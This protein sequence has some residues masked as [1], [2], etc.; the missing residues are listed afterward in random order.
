MKK[1]IWLGLFLPALL[2]LAPLPLLKKPVAAAT[3]AGVYYSELN[4]LEAPTAQTAATDVFTVKDHKTGEISQMTATDYI[5]GV[6]CGEMPI[7]FG[8]E[9]IKAQAVAAYTFACRRRQTNAAKNYDITTDYTVDQCYLSEAQ[10]REKWGDSAEENIAKIRTLVSEVSGYMVTYE[11]TAAL[12][13]YHATSAGKTQ[14]VSDVW[15]GELPYLCSVD[16]PGDTLSEGYVS[17]V[18][19]GRDEMAQKLGKICTVSAD[20]SLW[21]S[22][23][24]KNAAG[25]VSEITVCGKTVSGNALR[26]VL[27]LKSSC[28]EINFYDNTFTVTVKGNGHGVGMSQNGAAAMAANGSSFEEILCHYYPGCKVEK[29]S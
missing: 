27:S 1:I 29:I 14:N 6:I 10:A 22:N 25:Y 11:G 17:T 19:L 21:F 28:F 24:K 23:I 13:V 2:L 18:Q 7:S 5:C 12:T 16:S 3:S 8:D 15:G 20:A 4:E 9:A 26:E